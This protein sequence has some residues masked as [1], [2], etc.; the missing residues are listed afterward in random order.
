MPCWLFSD[1]FRLFLAAAVFTVFEDFDCQF[2]IVS[3]LKPASQQ[4]FESV[5]G[6]DEAAATAFDNFWTPSRSLSHTSH[7]ASMPRSLVYF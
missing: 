7:G 1:A 6:G 4:Q 5:G 3:K 2:A